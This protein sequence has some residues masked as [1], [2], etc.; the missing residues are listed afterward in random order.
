MKQSVTSALHKSL[1]R[2][3]RYRVHL[4]IAFL[5]TAPV[6][7]VF[8]GS[9]RIAA[10]LGGAMLALMIGICMV[11]GYREYRKRQLLSCRWL[12]GF[13]RMRG[14][15]P[16]VDGDGDL[17]FRIDNIKY[18]L[19]LKEHYFELHIGFGRKRSELNDELMARMAQEVMNSMRMVKILLRPE[20]VLFSIEC[21]QRR[22]SE[23]AEFF[24]SYIRILKFSVAE[25]TR[26]Y[27]EALEELHQE[28]RRQ[29][30]EED[31]S[32]RFSDYQGKEVVN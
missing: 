8:S 25:H 12:L 18:V 11:R 29:R 13:L 20:A 24:D 3:R 14:L 27:N 31:L 28:I 9:K 1:A 7:A 19:H 6:L 22:K 5:V 10:V 17:L 32:Q 30:E 21:L 4:I 23:F 15:E 26:R 2:L 16:E